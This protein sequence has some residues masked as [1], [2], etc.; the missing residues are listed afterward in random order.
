METGFGREF[1]RVRVHTGTQAAES[2]HSVGAHAY[3]VGPDIVFGHGRYNPGSAEGRDLLAHE[4]AHF[5]QEPAR[6]APGTD[7]LVGRPDDAVEHRAAAAARGIRAVSP[8]PVRLGSVPQ[9]GTRLRRQ[10]DPQAPAAG[11]PPQQQTGFVE[12]LVVECKD[13]E[14][15]KRGQPEG[16]L[17][18]VTAGGSHI[19]E[20]RRCRV[21]AGQYTATI[22]HKDHWASITLHTGESLEVDVS[23]AQHKR[24]FRSPAELLAG[25]DQVPVD[26]HPAGVATLIEEAEASE[27]PSE[28]LY[29]KENRDV[30][31]RQP[32]DY[33][34]FDYEPE[35]VLL[36]ARPLPLGPFG[37]LNCDLKVGGSAKAGTKGYYGPGTLHDLCLAKVLAHPQG[38]IE[39]H[40]KFTFPAR[41]DLFVDLEG[42][43]KLDAEV[44]IPYL[45]GGIEL[46][47]V[48]GKLGVHGNVA[49][50]LL[51]KTDTKVFYEVA[52]RQVTLA[53]D[54]GADAVVAF[55]LGI[56]AEVG[57]AV[58]GFNLWST[59]WHWEPVNET[60]DW[61]AGMTIGKDLG[62]TFD[63]DEAR[64]AGNKGGR[65]KRT[66]T[67]I[68]DF[69][70]AASRIADDVTSAI[71]SSKTGT[72]AGRKGQV[73]KPDGSKGNPMP[74][75]WYKPKSSYVKTLALP[76]N[77]TD[78]KSVD[79]DD[80]PVFVSYPYQSRSRN[81]QFGVKEEYWPEKDE[82]FL[83]DPKP[84]L[85]KDD[86][87]E[88]S[89]QY[90]FKRV[91]ESLGFPW[92]S[93]YQ[94]DHVR[95]LQFG[96]LDSFFNL[97]PLDASQNLRAGATHAD[98][99]RKT[100]EALGKSGH[101]Y[102]V[103]VKIVK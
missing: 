56:D 61:H 4:L 31:D 37:L 102:F 41:V 52:T 97:W 2:A 76:N 43:V 78:D 65:S 29:P 93:K 33:P 69:V 7:L 48:G 40:A 36:W 26:V 9:R 18:M 64:M 38:M 11:A 81:E 84:E 27:E 96:G 21:P 66:K 28:C 32:L 30:I 80:G 86:L 79:R 1:S 91:T 58:L 60:L 57:L 82:S 100:D 49:L 72:L 88:R 46:G 92:G 77:P 70:S 44:G 14:D 54:I 16:T 98:Q 23:K 50:D 39:G 53:G 6:P 19:F 101:Y 12:R 55:T 63:S 62:V 34:L 35:P 45:P 87:G 95:D 51:V 8:G 90:R 17:T 71:V 59:E 24:G 75:I 10:P 25:Q 3:A 103:I 22:A 74:F 15:R 67:K 47:H 89:E 20:M 83:Y 99:R 13:P 94:P 73:K 5:V 68:G 85:D 42:W